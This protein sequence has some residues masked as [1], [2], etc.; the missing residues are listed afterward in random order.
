VEGGSVTGRG[1]KSNRRLGKKQNLVNEKNHPPVGKIWW[2]VK[3]GNYPLSGAV[4][5]MA[6]MP[7]QLVSPSVLRLWEGVRR[8]KRGG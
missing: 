2:V 4:P 6:A 1:I 3:R 5:T 8:L 7:G